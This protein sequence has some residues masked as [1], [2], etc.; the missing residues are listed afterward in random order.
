LES[1]SEVVIFFPSRL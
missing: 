1:S